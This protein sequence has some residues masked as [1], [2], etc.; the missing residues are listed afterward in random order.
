MRPKYQ[1]EPQGLTYREFEIKKKGGKTRKICAPSKELKK[2][3]RKE[4]RELFKY[5]KK[6]TKGSIIQDTAHGFLRGKSCV[7]AA[8]HHIGFKTTI[9]M[10]ISAFFD[11]VT[12]AMIPKHLRK[13][14]FFHKEGRYTAQGFVTSPMLANIASI[15]MI[16]DIKE[17]L[18]LHHEDHAF[19]IYADDLSI[20]INS[21][22]YK[23]SAEIIRSVTTIIEAY[24]FKVNAKKTRIKYA[25]FGYRRILGINVGDT[26]IRATRKIMRK[27]RAA[28]H[29]KKGPSLGGLTQWSLC[30]APTY[31]PPWDGKPKPNQS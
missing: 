25:K 8:K 9:M 28:K 11:T 19:I 10:D 1:T 7:T 22:D 20:S 27:I 23:V 13:D 3:Q 29:Q 2:V 18:I 4:L 21:E 12:E 31:K 30:K 14:I 6:A 5:Y 24:R 15:D 16:S 26:E 17:Y